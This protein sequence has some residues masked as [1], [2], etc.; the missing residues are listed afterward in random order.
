M[1]IDRVE[2]REAT[3][4]RGAPFVCREIDYPARRIEA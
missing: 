1:A 3:G 4:S 2:A